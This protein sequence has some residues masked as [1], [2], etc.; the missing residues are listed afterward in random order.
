MIPAA[1]LVV[2]I[3]LVAAIPAIALR[4]WRSVELGSALIGCGLVIALL[5]RDP[6]SSLQVVGLGIDVDAP[7][8]VL[9]R[10][11]QVRGSERYPLLLLFVCAAVLFACS[12]SASQGWTYMPVGLGML[13]L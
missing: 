9:G 7:L 6:A 5:A 13:S 1:L 2:L 8:N 4:R 10:V 3:P 11:L 12:W